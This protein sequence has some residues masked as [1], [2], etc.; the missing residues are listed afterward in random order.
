MITLDTDLSLIYNLFNISAKKI[1]NEYSG[2]SIEQIMEAEATQGNT[3]AANFDKEILNDPVKLMEFFQLN[4][5]GN[6]YAILS[7]MNESDLENLLPLLNQSDMTAGLNFFTKDKLL[8]LTEE[9]PKDQLLKLVFNMFS[10]QQLMQLMPEEQLNKVLSSSGMDKGLELK[11]LQSINPEIL[12]QMLEAATGQSVQGAQTSSDNSGGSS[13]STQ[14]LMSQLIALPDDKFQEALLNMPKASKQGFVLK[15]TQQDSN[16][17]NLIDSSAY[18]NIINQKKDKQE[19]VQASNVISPEQL[20]KMLKELPQDLTAII[21]TQ[22]DPK[23]FADILISNFKN[24]LSQ[25][26]AG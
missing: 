13:L 17:F 8:K 22:I 25:I 23:K 16:I 6:K 9:L 19:I 1:A 20:V 4:N 11:V 7:N 18:T 14:A 10:P 15:L 26:I 5:V 24:I 2:M 12:A 21:M 3:Q